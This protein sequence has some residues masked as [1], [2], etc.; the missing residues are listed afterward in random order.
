[1]T[2]MMR[3]KM[4]KAKMKIRFVFYNG[5]RLV[6]FHV[7]VEL[8]LYL[9]PLK[10]SEEEEIGNLQLAWEMLEVAKVIYKR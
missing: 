2:T 9:L 8:H 6:L 4:M 1:M 3:V 7:L 10:E 5:F